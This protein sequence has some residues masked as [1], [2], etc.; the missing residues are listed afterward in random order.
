MIDLNNKILQVEKS[1]IKNNQEITINGYKHAMVQIICASIASNQIINIKNVPIV[2]D[3]IILC[4]IINSLGGIAKINNR[5]L[6]LDP[7]NMKYCSIDPELTKKIHGSIYLIP[8]LAVR[9][10]KFDFFESGGCQIGNKN[11]NGKRPVSHIAEVLQKFDF[12]IVKD[13]N[14]NLMYG[15]LKNNTNKNVIIDIMNFSE[16]TSFLS[17]P[18]I[19]GSTKIAIICSLNIEKTIILNPYLKT[20]VA[21]LLRF[22]KN[23]GF[24]VKILDNNKRIEITKIKNEKKIINFYLTSCVS[25]VITYITLAVC[26]NISI[27]LKVNNMEQVINGLKQEFS[28]LKVM[29]VNI[30]HNDNTITVNK[31][32]FPLNAVNIDVTDTTIQSDHHPF[33]ALMLLKANKKSIIREFVWK[34]RFSYAEELKKIGADFLIVDNI[35]TINPSILKSNETKLICSD[36]R[37]GA[38][39]LLAALESEGKSLIYD[40]YHIKRGYENLVENLILLGGKIKI[41]NK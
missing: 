14:N 21:D 11:S 32:N 7:T 37:A 40:S 2:D 26:N 8:A 28:I 6:F 18:K 4:N 3:T 16:D 15:K 25:E 38:I 20:D 19:S 5:N 24:D 39:I 22:I 12:D 34:N 9:F 13:N 35:L 23:I 10:K 36:T 33:F 41:I 30:T 27:N 31:I 17:G 1:T 29:G